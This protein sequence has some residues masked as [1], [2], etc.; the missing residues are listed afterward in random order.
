LRVFG[1]GNKETPAAISSITVERMSDRR[2]VKLKW[3]EIPKATGYIVRFGTHK[4]KLYQ[5]YMVYGK[6][7]VTINALN[8]DQTYFFTVDAFN[9]NGITQGE[10][11]VES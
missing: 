1:K 9:E 4:N 7:N 3:D 8:V 11:R 10:L 5:S 2:T 6:N